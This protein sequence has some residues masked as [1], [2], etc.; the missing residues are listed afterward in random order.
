MFQILDN[1][2][3][4]DWPEASRAK[5]IIRVTVAIDSPFKGEHFFA[6]VDGRREENK[7]EFDD[8]VSL[9]NELLDGGQ[10]V[11]VHCVVGRS[12]SAAVVLGVLMKRGLTFQEAYQLLHQKHPEA[13]PRL[14]L[15]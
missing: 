11:V 13:D 12:R 1:L 6:L 3:I 5:D 14:S 4:S 15:F 10:K 2:Y 7:Q 9:V 8:A